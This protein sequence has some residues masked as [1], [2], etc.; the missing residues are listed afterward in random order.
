MFPLVNLFFCHTHV[1]TFFTGLS[2][3]RRKTCS[4]I[5]N[6]RLAV[7]SM[8]WRLLDPVLCNA[9]VDRHLQT[10]TSMLKLLCQMRDTDFTVPLSGTVTS[11]S[12][13]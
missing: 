4:T 1:V 10:A 5:L 8:S 13:L 12:H 7:T 9:A 11:H 6:R 3:V 2:S